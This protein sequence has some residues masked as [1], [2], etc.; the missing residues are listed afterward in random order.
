MMDDVAPSEP[1]A[2]AT[3]TLEKFKWVSS[4]LNS[5]LFMDNRHYP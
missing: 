2:Q 5:A 4:Q 3:V 1:Q